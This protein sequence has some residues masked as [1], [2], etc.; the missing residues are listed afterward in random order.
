MR[1]EVLAQRQFRRPFDLAADS[2]LRVTAVR[3]SN[4]E[5]MLLITAHHIAWDDAS[6]GPFF[7]DLTRAYSDTAGLDGATPPVPAATAGT[8]TRIWPI[9]DR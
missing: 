1:L 6:W 3:L 7:T 9:G 8:S 2:P 5:L 4:D